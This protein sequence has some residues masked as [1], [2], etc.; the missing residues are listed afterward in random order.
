[1]EWPGRMAPQEGSRESREQN[2]NIQKGIKFI[3][4]ADNCMLYSRFKPCEN[5]ICLAVMSRDPWRL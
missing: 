1:M 5:L 3:D 4:H 2:K